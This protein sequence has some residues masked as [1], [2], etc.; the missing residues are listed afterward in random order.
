MN[1]KAYEGDIIVFLQSM[2]PKSSAQ[3]DI[4]WIGDLDKIVGLLECSVHG[5]GH[6]H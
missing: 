1:L 2:D 6:F 3:L 5:N 4:I